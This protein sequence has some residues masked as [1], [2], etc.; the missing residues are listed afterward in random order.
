MTT[1]TFWALGASEDDAVSTAQDGRRFVV[2]QDALDAAK[3]VG[4]VAGDEVKVYIVTMIVAEDAQ[5]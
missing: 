2:K 5:P 3:V 4:D 1:N